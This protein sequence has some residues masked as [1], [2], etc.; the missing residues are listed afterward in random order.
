MVSG[1]GEEALER[2]AAGVEAVGTVAE[3]LALHLLDEQLVAVHGV[4]CGALAVGGGGVSDRAVA[5][6]ASARPDRRRCAEALELA[7]SD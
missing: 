1:G 5:E 6:G 2:L 3:L 4:P 7:V